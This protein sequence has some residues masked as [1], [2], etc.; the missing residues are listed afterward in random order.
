MIGR[1]NLSCLPFVTELIVNNCCLLVCLVF[2]TI[3]CVVSRTQIVICR[4]Q[5]LQVILS[6]Q[7]NRIHPL[8]PVCFSAIECIPLLDS[9]LVLVDVTPH[10]LIIQHMLLT[11]YSVFWATVFLFSLYDLPWAIYLA[12]TSSTVTSATQVAVDVW[13]E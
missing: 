12:N 11:L 6:W 5:S 10:D 4:S 7:S 2:I 8:F 13:T 3:L 9:G 1:L